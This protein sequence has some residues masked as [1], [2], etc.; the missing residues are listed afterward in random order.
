VIVTGGGTGGHIYPAIAVV[1]ALR[2]VDSD[3]EIQY[4][5]GKTGPETEIVPAAGIPFISVES[6]KLRRLA[7]PS[8]LAVL[9]SLVKGYRQASQFIKEFG[10][11][12]VISTGGYVAAAAGLAAANRNIPLITQACDAVPGRTN[13]WLGKRARRICV[14]FEETKKYFPAGRAVVTGVP[15]RDGMVS[16]V[17]PAGARAALGLEPERLTLLVMGG[18]QGARRLNELTVGMPTYLKADLQI[19]HQTGPRNID[20]VKAALSA[21]N[22]E[23]IP[24]H[25][26]PYLSGDEVPMAYRAADLLICRCGI[27]TLAEITANRIPALMVPLPTAYADHQTANAREVERAGGGIL[28][29]EA[30]LRSEELARQVDRLAAD[31]EARGR[32]SEAGA[33]LGR[34]HAA[35]EIARLAIALGNG[36]VA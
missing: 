17:S 30:S 9:W 36:Q 7:S 15:L 3:I 31:S 16:N 18:S 25:V 4:I 23:R 33:K 20:D 29:P 24:Y 14:W 1:E 2:K 10:P 27:S 32:M 21:V 35:E 28:L 13:L 6:R 12:V 8:T 19:L 26:R 34:P 22:V 11:S 5:G